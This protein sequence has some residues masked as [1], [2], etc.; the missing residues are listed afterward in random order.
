[1]LLIP[2]QGHSLTLEEI[3]DEDIHDVSE[4]VIST[5]KSTL[6]YNR[7][8]FLIKINNE[9][10]IFF[11]SDPI[12]TNGVKLEK[13][14]DQNAVLNF[15]D[16]YKNINTLKLNLKPINEK[17]SLFFFDLLQRIHL[18]KNIEFHHCE[19]SEDI[20]KTID[21]IK[22]FENIVEIVIANSIWDETC[23]LYFLYC[24]KNEFFKHLE[25]IDYRYNSWA[26]NDVS[27][28]SNI[29]IRNHI[30]K[31]NK[32]RLNKIN[33]NFSKNNDAFKFNFKLHNSLYNTQDEE[34]LL[35]YLEEFSSEYKKIITNI[36][37]STETEAQILEKYGEHFYVV[38]Q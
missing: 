37:L 29:I 38:D 6:K 31:I 11:G 16:S 3:L 32:K 15:L 9:N 30:E 17:N 8:Y 22:D 19:S 23:T 24:I 1:M 27:N 36:P 33:H 28:C 12:R 25:L 10:E 7:T 26:N 2:F 4:N 14:E 34:A 35:W 21:R 20:C 13:N 18:I 5:L